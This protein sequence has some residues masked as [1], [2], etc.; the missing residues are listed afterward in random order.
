MYTS[1]IPSYTIDLSLPEE[2]RWAQTIK[3]EKHIARRLCRQ[4]ME[5]YERY[6][7]LLARAVGGIFRKVY[8]LYGGRYEGEIEAWAQALAVSPG[9]ATMLNC[10]YEL[11]HFNPRQVF[12]CTAG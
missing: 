5:D 4:A 8:K 12:G 10:C 2:E 9:V 1:N 6:P 7:G 11:S 3:K